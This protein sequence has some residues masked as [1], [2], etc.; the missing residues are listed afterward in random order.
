MGGELIADRFDRR[1]HFHVAARAATIRETIEKIETAEIHVSLISANLQDGPLSGFAALRQL[2]ERWPNIRAIILLDSPESRLAV[3]AFRAGARGVFCLSQSSF[4]MLCKCIQRVHEG[5]I[6]AN[7]EQLVN[8]TEALAQLG[9]LRVVTAEGKKLLTK[10]EEAVVALLSEGLT[11]KDI[12]RE[13][14]LSEHTVK[15]YL[16][17]IFDKLG[18]SSR[19]ELVL[20]AL[21]STKPA[22]AATAG[23]EE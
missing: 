22:Q 4:K 18:I 11:N 8:V 6:W 20:Y 5:Q 14:N 3:D 13:L 16:F 2:R 19:I 10:R 7:S 23:D 1:S 15:N 21:S 12:A 17:H 9:P